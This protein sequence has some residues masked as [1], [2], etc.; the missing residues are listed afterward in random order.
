MKSLL[1]DIRPNGRKL[2][3]ENPVTKQVWRV[4]VKNDNVS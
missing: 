2:I 4:C 1:E 3:W